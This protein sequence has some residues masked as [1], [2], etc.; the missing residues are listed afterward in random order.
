MPRWYVLLDGPASDLVHVKRLFTTSGFTFDEKDGKD[1]LSAPELER[2]DDEKDV[3]SAAMELL[4]SINVAVRLS[5]VAYA[6]FGF[7]GLVEV[8]SDGTTHRRMI[9]QAGSYQVSGVAAVGLVGTIGKPVRSREERL[10]SLIDKNSA[11]ADLAVAMTARPLTWGAMSTTYES[12]KGLMSKKGSDAD[13]RADYQGLIDRGWITEDESRSF[14][15]TAAY[16]RHGYPRIEMKGVPAM[17]YLTA[18]RLINK[19]FWHLVD[20]LEPT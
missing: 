20:E 11:V 4:T 2:L 14:Y 10:V 18:S 16:N 8:R 9:A 5:V 7:H 12:A 19:L 1:T 15:Q 13:R 3:T 6:G 17:E